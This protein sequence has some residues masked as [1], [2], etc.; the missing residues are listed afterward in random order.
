M[1]ERCRGW[2]T[3]WPAPGC[4]SSSTSG[5]RPPWGGGPPTGSSRACRSASS[6]GPATSPRTWSRW[7]RRITGRQGARAASTASSRRSSAALRERPGATCWP[8][9]PSAATPARSTSRPSPRPPRRRRPGG[10]ASPGPTLGDDGEAELAEQGITVRCLVMPDGSLP[11]QRRRARRPGR[12][13]PGLVLTRACPAARSRTRLR[14]T[15]GRYTP[16]LHSI[17]VSTEGVGSCP[18]LSFD[19]QDRRCAPECHD[20]HQREEVEQR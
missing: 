6:S 19:G 9:P 16:R 18:R 7:S 1:I 12:G 14:Y 13:R 11:V 15:P 10:P 2:P 17:A 20:E 3:S 8:R 5:S 4:G